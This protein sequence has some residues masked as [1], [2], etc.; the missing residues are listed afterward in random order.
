[1]FQQIDNKSLMLKT[2]ADKVVQQ[3]RPT[4]TSK[5][6]KENDNK[7]DQI[8]DSLVVRLRLNT[9]NGMN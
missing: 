9:F 4:T 2:K 3:F 5:R 7:E 6:L 8:S 1:M